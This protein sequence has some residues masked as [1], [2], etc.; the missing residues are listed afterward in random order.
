MTHSCLR[1]T[2]RPLVCCILM[3]VLLSVTITKATGPRRAFETARRARRLAGKEPKTKLKSLT[4]EKKKVLGDKWA[5]NLEIT[6]GQTTWKLTGP[7]KDLDSTIW[8]LSRVSKEIE[9]SDTSVF[10]RIKNALMYSGS[11]QES[12]ANIPRP[13]RYALGTEGL[14]NAVYEIAFIVRENHYQKT[15]KE[16]KEFIENQSDSTSTRPSAYV[17]AQHGYSKTIYIVRKWRHWF[18]RGSRWI[19]RWWRYQVDYKNIEIQI[20]TVG[21]NGSLEK[22]P[23]L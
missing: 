9:D 20:F 15:L 7:D 16:L 2:A 3:L 6:I 19:G 10:F 22:K 1:S 13:V 5:D 21:K 8:T 17:A 12:D 4:R 11:G 18:L 14:K 23:S